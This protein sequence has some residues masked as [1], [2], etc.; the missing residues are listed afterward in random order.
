MRA[1]YVI[2]DG[3]GRELVS[4][5]LAWSEMTANAVFDM[6]R[7]SD[8]RFGGGR[9]HAYFSFYLKNFLLIHMHLEN[10]NGGYSY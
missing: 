2:L 9:G 4:A 10:S 6:E 3:I 1:K 5:H 7:L 8:C